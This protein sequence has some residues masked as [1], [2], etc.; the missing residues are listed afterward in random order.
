MSLHDA[1]D[2]TRELMAAEAEYLDPKWD[3]YWVSWNPIYI[4]GRGWE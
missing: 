2:I 4:K 1:R 3:R